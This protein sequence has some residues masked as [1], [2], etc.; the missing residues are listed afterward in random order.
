MFGW[1]RVWATVSIVLAL[2]LMGF[3]LHWIL[4]PGVAPVVAQANFRLLLSDEENAI[5]DFDSLNIWIA[6]IGLLHG[7]ESG[8]WIEF[9]PETQSVDLTLVQGDNAVEIWRGQI[10]EGQYTKV[11][12]FVDHVSGVLGGTGEVVIVKL[13]SGR[14]QIPTPFE[15]SADSLVDFVYDLTVVAAGNEQSGGRYILKPQIG[16]SGSGHEFNEVLWGKMEIKG[17]IQDFELVDGEGWIQ[18]EGYEDPIAIEKN[19][20]IEGTLKI[21]VIVEVEAVV[22]PDGSL[23]ATEIEVE[24]EGEE[25]DE[26]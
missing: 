5:G 9:E 23:L 22:Q 3:G 14:L 6:S 7:G 25:E 26:D 10:P 15:V 11:F 1:P 20:E 21:G 19:T 12:I 8:S 24:E 17:K 2:A 18:I 16:Q 13:P 4:T